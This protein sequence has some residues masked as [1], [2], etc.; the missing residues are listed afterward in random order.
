[1]PQNTEGS[2]VKKISLFTDK[3]FYVKYGNILIFLYLASCILVL[4]KINFKQP[5]N[6][7]I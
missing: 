2:F 1:M 7:N 5:K 6:K 3:T 4:P